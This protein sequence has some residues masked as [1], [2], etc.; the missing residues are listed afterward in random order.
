MCIRFLNIRPLFIAGFVFMSQ[1]TE[2]KICIK[3]LKN[4]FK[5][6]SPAAN[7]STS[8]AGSE[9]LNSA[10][11]ASAL[12]VMLERERCELSRASRNIKS[13]LLNEGNSFVFRFLNIITGLVP[14]MTG[15]GNACLCFFHSLN[16]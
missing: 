12:N 11:N 9:V 8:P 14:V 4:G 6:P 5:H 1:Q 16:Y 10:F 7:A 2:L 13:I 3:F 15:A